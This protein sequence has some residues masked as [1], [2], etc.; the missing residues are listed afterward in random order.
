MA[1]KEEIQENPYG[2]ETGIVALDLVLGGYLPLG[3]IIELNGESACVDKDTEFFNGHEWKKIS[4]YTKEDKVLQYDLELDKAMLVEPDDYIKLPCSKITEI[5]SK[6][7]VNQCLTDNHVVPYITCRGHWK[8]TTFDEV[9]K[10]HNENI[11]GFRGR[12]KTTFDYEGSGIL[13]SDNMIRLAVAIF[14]DGHFPRNSTYCVFRLKK[15]RKIT[16]LKMLLDTLNIKYR[17]DVKDGYTVIVFYAPFREKHYPKEWYQC[18]KEQFRVITD[19]CLLW[20]GCLE[21]RRFSTC[22]KADADFIQFACATIGIRATISV[23]D[24]VGKPYK[25]GGKDYIRKSVEYSVNFTGNNLVSIMKGT[26]NKNPV[27]PIEK[28]PEDGYCYCF[29]VP[30]GYL[31]L[32]RGNCIFV[33]GNCGK[34]TL[35]LYLSSKLCKQG[36]K[37]YYIDIERGVTEGIMKNMNLLEHLGKNFVLDQKTSLYSELQVVMDEQIGKDPK[38]RTEKPVRT[39]NTPDLIILDSLAMLVP[40]GSKEKTIDSNVTNNM[41]AARYATQMF[42]DI[43]GDLAEVNTTFLFINHTQTKMKKIGFN[44]Q[45]AYQDSAGSSIVK[46]GPDV[47]LYMS[48]TK[49]L[50]VIR[51]TVVGNQE[52]RIGATSNI[53]TKKSRVEDNGIKMPIK[54]IDAYGVFNGY[55]LRPICE[56]LGW[57]SGS[58]GHYYVQKQIVP[59]ELHD[60]VKEKGYYINGSNEVEIYCQQNANLIVEALKKNH[61]YRLTLDRAEH[62]TMM[63]VVQKTESKK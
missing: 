3:K 17:F 15:E 42:K 36:K 16:R 55:T 18:T 21:H 11:I 24:R 49:E 46:Y 41:L 32:R 13:L 43:V 5:K 29:T 30:S 25:T 40:D 12:F 14:A 35:A 58:G 8:T 47:R 31:V 1:K 37:V 56:N 7:G 19:E 52:A 22:C 20:D 61:L 4:E 50:K 9:V 53:W 48:D 51:K 28:T 60:K 6:F 33:T 26:A 62:K 38:D 23:N 39:D 34:S 63:D 27:I 2:V 44:M 10:K 57:I 54:M 45:M 59:K